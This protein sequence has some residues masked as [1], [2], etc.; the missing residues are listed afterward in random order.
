MR[1][2]LSTFMIL[3]QA[4]V[5]AGS[6]ILQL[7]TGRIF[8]YRSRSILLYLAAMLLPM[9][10]ALRINSRSNRTP[11]EKCAFAKTSAL[12]FAGTYLVLLFHLVFVNQLRSAEDIGLREFFFANANLI[13][14][15]TVFGM[16]GD[17]LQRGNLLALVNICGNLALLAPLGF[18]LPM[19]FQS[20]RRK[21]LFFA[22]LFVIACGIE[23]GQVYLRVGKFDVDDIILNVMGGAISYAVC[24]LR[25]V[26]RWLR[27]RFPGTAYEEA[28]AIRA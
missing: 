19:G 1:K 10:L 14:F 17:F 20:M 18:L 15:R 23:A 25:C 22:V 26:Q 13:P 3:L 4:A 6:L 2:I 8:A 28:A 24:H 11:D 9:L 5:F 27:R 16:A 21:P 7:Q 12:L